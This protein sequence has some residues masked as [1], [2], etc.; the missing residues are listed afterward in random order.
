M[1]TL[2]SKP[3]ND[4]L[5]FLDFGPVGIG[6]RLALW[7]KRGTIGALHPDRR[8]YCYPSLFSPWNAGLAEAAARGNSR[9][10]AGLGPAPCHRV[11]E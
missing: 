8:L 5:D 1:P 6:V 9:R 10:F 7:R 2:C 11:E 4:F 3:Q